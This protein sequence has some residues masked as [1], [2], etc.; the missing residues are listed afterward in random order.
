MAPR[1]STFI[2]SPRPES[3]DEGICFQ[4]LS[5]GLRTSELHVHRKCKSFNLS[6]PLSRNQLPAIREVVGLCVID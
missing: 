4:Q 6:K 2:V 5:M 3:I 1:C